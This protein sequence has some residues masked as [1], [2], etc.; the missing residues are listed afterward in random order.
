MNGMNIIEELDSSCNNG[1]PSVT[2]L[3]NALERKKAWPE[4]EARAAGDLLEKLEAVDFS[5]LDARDNSVLFSVTGYDR[6]VKVMKHYAAVD[7]ELDSSAKYAVLFSAA[8][9]KK[10]PLGKAVTAGGFLREARI[11]AVLRECG[12]A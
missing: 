5:V 1:F 9:K 2:D 7:G 4:N 12:L 3:R 6:L 8:G 10:K 11:P